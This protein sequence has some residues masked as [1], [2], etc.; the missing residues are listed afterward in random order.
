MY[1]FQCFPSYFLRSQSGSFFLGVHLTTQVSLFPST[2]VW[3]KSKT[4][5]LFIVWIA[6]LRT[7]L[8]RNNIF[9]KRASSGTNDRPWVDGRGAVAQWHR[10]G[11]GPE[12]ARRRHTPLIVRA[13]PRAPAHVAWQRRKHSAGDA[14]LPH[15]LPVWLLSNRIPNAVRGGG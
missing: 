8:Q 15:T 12:H 3:S 4:S 1:S 13:T 14:P 11:H 7:T 6:S 10:S 9:L 5:K 2:I